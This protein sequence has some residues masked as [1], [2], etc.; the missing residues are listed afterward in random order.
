MH[1]SATSVVPSA[2]LS[3]ESGSTFT[4]S[5]EPPYVRT[6]ERARSVLMGA[7]VFLLPVQVAL[8]PDLRLAVSDVFVAAYLVLT[9]FSLRRTRG[10]WT[11]WYP[12]LLGVIGLGLV[13]SLATTG[14]FTSYA[15]LQK[16]IGLV[17]LLLTMACLLDYLRTLEQ[18]RWL[19]KVFLAGV[20]VNVVVS[21]LA[22]GVQLSNADAFPQINYVGTR[23]SG[24]LVDPNAFGGLLACAL[25]VHL[26]TARTPVAVVP[27]RARAAVTGLLAIALVLTFSRSAWIATALG[28][29]VAIVVGGP[30]ARRAVTGLIVAVMLAV[31]LLA[32]LYVPD[33]ARLAS[34]PSQVGARFSLIDQALASFA[35]SPL[36]GIGLGVFTQRH[37]EIVH[38]SGLW[39]LAEMGLIGLLV[40]TGFVI[41]F[42]L[43][44]LTLLRTTVGAVATFALAMLAAHAAMIGLSIGIEALYQR[45]WWLMLSIGGAL[46]GFEHVRRTRSLAAAAVAPPS[47]SSSS[48]S[49]SS[50]MPPPTVPPT[51]PPSTIPPPTTPPLTIPPPTTSA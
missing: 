11:I 37:G 51:T 23:L 17:V 20:L 24:L 1:P 35:E 19:L 7:Y 39:F 44:M 5:A 40:F 50:A 33:L 31:P 32:A 27:D 43:R 14:S 12:A 38:N 3:D 46:V 4:R 13:V 36:Y 29:A 48:A 8:G 15:L 2:T 26:F 41:S 42:G 6:G 16:G 22:F 9:S 10:T 18:V 30:R 28:I 49:S 45:H 47:A 25:M 21:L 34:R